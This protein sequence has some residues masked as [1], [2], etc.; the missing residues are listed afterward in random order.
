MPH[1]TAAWR[2][3]TF[4]VHIESNLRELVKIS[5]IN[6][7]NLSLLHRFQLVSTV[8][9]SPWQSAATSALSRRKISGSET[10]F[11]LVFSSSVAA[12]MS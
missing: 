7:I 8:S 6:P 2:F 11:S 10:F 9:A 12:H 5:S 1:E 4:K 3:M